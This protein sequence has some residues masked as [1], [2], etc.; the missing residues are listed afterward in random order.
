MGQVKA[1]TF[2]GCDLV[3]VDQLQSSAIGNWFMCHQRRETIQIQL[4]S[5]VFGC[6][7]QVKVAVQSRLASVVGTFFVLRVGGRR[8]STRRQPNRRAVSLQPTCHKSVDS[9]PSFFPYY[10][11]SLRCFAV[12]PLGCCPSSP[13]YDAL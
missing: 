13:S 1:Q 3:V 9:S 4:H 6:F 2:C 10:S 11:G 12:H 8:H 7:K 5:F